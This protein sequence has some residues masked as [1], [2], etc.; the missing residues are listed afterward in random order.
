MKLTESELQQIRDEAEK[1]YPIDG[2]MPPEVQES[3]MLKRVGYIA[4]LTSER[5]K[6]KQ[7]ID[8]LEKIANPIKYIRQEAEKEGGAL[9]GVMAIQISNDANY[10]K[11]IAQAAL[12]NYQKH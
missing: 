5:E 1:V 4:A 3:R 2:L 10:L 7:L 6:T 12:T 9:N 8:A 11:G